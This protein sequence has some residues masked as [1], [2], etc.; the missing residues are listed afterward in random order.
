MNHFYKI[1]F[2]GFYPFGPIMSSPVDLN[3]LSQK[4]TLKSAV[5]LPLLPEFPQPYLP[6]VGHC[7]ESSEKD[8]QAIVYTVG[9]F[10]QE[11]LRLNRFCYIQGLT[12]KPSKVG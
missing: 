8:F 9:R 7:S 4:R 5:L 3:E 1:D 12:N 2:W 11:T 10:S 6:Y